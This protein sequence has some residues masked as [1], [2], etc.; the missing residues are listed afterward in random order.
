MLQCKENV[1]KKVKR[2]QETK[3]SSRIV[4]QILPEKIP[5]NQQNE[6]IILIKTLCTNDHN[7]Q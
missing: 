6:I 1:K 3:K 2:P 7:Y 5:Q 4:K